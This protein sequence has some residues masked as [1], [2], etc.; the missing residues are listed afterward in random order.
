MGLTMLK[1]VLTSKPKISR[2]AMEVCFLPLY[3]I[4][5]TL[6]I[7]HPNKLE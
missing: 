7:S 1:L 2:T 5:L 4:S 6:V 3:T